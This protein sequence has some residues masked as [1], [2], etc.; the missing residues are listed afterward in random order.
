MKARG[1][2][3]RALVVADWTF[4]CFER[5]LGLFGQEKQGA[6]TVVSPAEED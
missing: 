2:N 1:Q 6:A 5:M 3:E 4:P